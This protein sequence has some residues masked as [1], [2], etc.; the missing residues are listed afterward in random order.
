MQ[1]V[2]KRIS[3]RRWDVP[4]SVNSTIVHNVYICLVEHGTYERHAR[5]LSGVVVVQSTVYAH[6]LCSSY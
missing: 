4:K 6:V 1:G 2:K 3:L 5:V